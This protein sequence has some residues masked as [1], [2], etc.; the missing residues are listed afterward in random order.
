[1]DL[2]FRFVLLLGLLGEIISGIVKKI[3]PHWERL[4]RGFYY[5]ATAISLIVNRV[6]KT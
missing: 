1:M 2:L 5:T 4:N 3:S 6:L